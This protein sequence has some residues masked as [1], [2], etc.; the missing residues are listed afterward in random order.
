MTKKSIKK[1]YIL[2]LFNQVLNLLTPFVTTPYISRVLRADGI[3]TYSY[4]AAIV[5]YFV[6]FAGLGTSIYGQRQIAYFQDNKEERSRS[7]WEIEIL[8][9]VSTVICAI[10]YILYCSIQKENQYIYMIYVLNII[11][12]AIDISWFFSGMEEFSK[13]VIRNTFFKII[14]IILIFLFVK[15][16]NDLILYVIFITLL[17]VLSAISLWGYVSKFL[18]RTSI[19]NLQPIKHIK[20]TLALFIPTIAI[21]V[22]SSLDKVMLGSIVGNPYENGYYEQ[23]YKLVRIVLTFVAAFGT[24]LIPRVGYYYNNGK[25]KEMKSIIMKGFNFAWCIGFPSAFGLMGCSDNI[26]PWF[27]GVGYEKMAV[28]LKVFSLLI[29]IVGLNNVTGMQYLIPTNR[30]NIFTKTVIYGALIN[31]ILNYVLIPRY[32]SVGAAVASVIAEAVVLGTELFAIRKE[33]S[34]SE[35]FLLSWKYFVASIVMFVVLRIENNFMSS[36]IINTIIM[37]I[38]GGSVYLMIL[39]LLKDNFFYTQILPLIFKGLKFINRKRV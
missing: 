16:K 1:N 6:L 29:I 2:N 28:L 3:G 21:Q 34:L 7:F 10:F 27:F 35:I 32:M 24:V 8:S 12:V 30:Q 9:V 15:E 11:T 4:I 31:I 17:P 37:C 13:I 36:S 20:G 25:Y 19:K 39:I 22:Y 5:S 33:F 26:I 18:V 38:S 14:N 23:S